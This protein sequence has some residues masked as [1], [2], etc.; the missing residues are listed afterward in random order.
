VFTLG[1]LGYVKGGIGWA[2]TNVAAFVPGRVTGELADITRAGY[3]VGAGLEWKFAPGWS[4]FCEYNYLYFGTKSSNLYATGLVN[5][6][7]GP[8]L[9]PSRTSSRCGFAA[10]KPSSASTTGSTGLARSSRNTDRRMAAT[11]RYATAALARSASGR[12]ARILP[13]SRCRSTGLVSK[14]EQPASTLLA[15]SLASA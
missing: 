11:L 5:P 2:S 7:F 6:G 8:E 15:R 9:E 4:V 14:S 10:R 1:V 13:S 3:T 12:S